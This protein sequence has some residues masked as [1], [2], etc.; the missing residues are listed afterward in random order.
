MRTFGTRIANDEKITISDADW[1]QHQYVIGASGGGRTNYLETLM[2]QD[3]A[4][5][6]GL[7]FID[8]HG[9]SAKRIADSA[10]Q[11]IIYWKPADLSYMIGLNPLQNV[12]PDER[13]RVTAE[14]VS[15]FSD[16]WQLGPETP[17]LLYYLRGAVRLLLDTP[18]TALLD[19]RKT[20][21]DGNFR[22]KLIRTCSDQETMQTR[23]EFNMKDARQQA[24]EI[25]SLQNKVAALADALPL[26]LILGQ[27]TSTI[28]IRRIIDRGTVMVVDLSGMGEE[29]ARFL[30][31]LLVSQF[32]QAAEA[33]ADVGRARGLH[34]LHRR[35]PELRFADI[36]QDDLERGAQVAAVDRA[37]PPVHRP[38]RGERLARGGLRELRDHR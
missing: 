13:W 29:P 22:T 7:C 30:G 1:R 9:D 18:G 37:R 4:A 33:R 2:A 38:D 27:K 14:I 15:V 34:A 10:E 19:I 35:V 20:L 24:Q 26:G 25:N 8:K 3:L 5:G 36:C 21:V 12:P 16:I 17:R 23:S 31:A 32:A 28:D 11:P 6:R